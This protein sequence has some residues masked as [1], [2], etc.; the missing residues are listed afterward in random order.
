MAILRNRKYTSFHAQIVAIDKEQTKPVEEM[1]KV[2]LQHFPIVEVD[3]RVLLTGKEEP[4]ANAE[5]DLE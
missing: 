3:E 2:K 5:I 4:P 1:A